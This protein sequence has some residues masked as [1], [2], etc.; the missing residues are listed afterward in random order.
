M[1]ND[2]LSDS[3]GVTPDM[4]RQQAGPSYGYKGRP[5]ELSRAG[6]SPFA[7]VAPLFGGGGAGAG[8]QAQR[9]AAAQEQKPANPDAM[10]YS[11]VVGDV[12]AAQALANSKDGQSVFQIF[13]N[14]D[15]DLGEGD[16][17]GRNKGN[18]SLK[19]VPKGDRIVNTPEGPQKLPLWYYA[20]KS[21]VTTAPFKGG[22]EAAGSFRTLLSDSQGLMKNLTTLEKIY[23]RNSVVLNPLDTSEDAAEARGLEARILVD[24]SRI[25]SGAKG[26]GGQV[27]D[28][29]LSIFQSMT[30][31]RASSFFSRLKGNEEALIRRMRV[32]ILDKIRSS[33]Q[34]NGLD[35]VDLSEGSSV[36]D[37][38]Y[39]SKSVKL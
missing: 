14:Y 12:P 30:P 39:D 13:D 28:R 37:S 22:D 11:N 18:I 25:M 8:R 32:Q 27:S 29:D 26:L 36:N 1:R 20:Q 35:L 4:V 7:E 10:F 21:G 5:G 3:F 15:F 19:I 34:A 16:S 24:F 38:I 33:A 9:P 17:E 23:A 31:Q 2:P 6:M